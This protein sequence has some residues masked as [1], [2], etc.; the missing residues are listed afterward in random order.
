[1]AKLNPVTKMETKIEATTYKEFLTPWWVSGTEEKA[2][3]IEIQANYVYENIPIKTFGGYM[4]RA[5][6][7]TNGKLVKMENQ[8]PFE[9]IVN[10]K[11][12]VLW[13]LSELKNLETQQFKVWR[14]DGGLNYELSED[15]VNIDTV[16]LSDYSLEYIYDIKSGVVWPYYFLNGES[17]LKT[18][19]AKVKLII[20]AVKEQ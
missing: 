1:M 12:K 9:K 5:N 3:S 18:G 7:L 14:V 16:I 11:E 20:S 19:K 15:A 6:Y 10:S 4:I 13:T 2:D 17:D 8:L